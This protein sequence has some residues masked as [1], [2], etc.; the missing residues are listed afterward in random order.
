MG[1]ANKVPDMEL[2]PSMVGHQHPLE[3]RGVPRL[4]LPLAWILKAGTSK[5]TW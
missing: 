5:Y 3:Y 4:G 2:A 1:V